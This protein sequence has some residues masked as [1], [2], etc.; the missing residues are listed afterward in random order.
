M[1]NK[2]VTGKLRATLHQTLHKEQQTESITKLKD[3]N[4]VRNHNTRTT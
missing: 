1:V 2:L 4:I 3:Y